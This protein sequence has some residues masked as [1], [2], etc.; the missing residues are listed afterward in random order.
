VLAEAG[1][2]LGGTMTTGG[3]EWPGLFFAWGKQVVAGIG[4]E[5]V[6]ATVALQGDALP[7]FSQ[8]VGTAMHRHPNFQVPLCGGLYAALAEEACTQAGV[9]LRY[10]ESPTSVAPDGAGWVVTTAGKGV[11]ARIR[12]RQLVD[13]TANASVVDLAGFERERGE[14]RQPGSIVY[15]LTQPSGWKSGPGF[16]HQRYVL[17]ADVSTAETHT[18]ANLRGRAEFLKAFRALKASAEGKDARV[19]S[20]QP[21]T[22]SRETYR[23]VGEYQI[24]RDDYATGR[25]H[26]D[27]VAC[28]YYP[29]DLHTPSGVKPQHLPDG[30]TVTIPLRALIPRGSHSLLVA[31]RCVAS[32]RLANSGLRVQA[33]CMAMGQAAGTA[34]ALAAQAGVTPGQVSLAALRAALRTHGVVLPA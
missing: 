9:A 24:T 31:G 15:T 5:L 13:C 19:L 3:V 28:M 11:R 14:D 22:N 29:I 25:V 16:K 30:T 8:S 32:D 33:S 2:Q 4:W 21:E 10:Y 18:A 7:D 23:I 6:R 34:A 12:C 26:D 17:G 1:S 20:V 27:A